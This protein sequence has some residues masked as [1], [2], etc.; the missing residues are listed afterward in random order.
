VVGGPLAALE[1]GISQGYP[2]E[3]TCNQNPSK[4]TSLAN[5]R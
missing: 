3:S 4:Q 1:N 2:V 5:G